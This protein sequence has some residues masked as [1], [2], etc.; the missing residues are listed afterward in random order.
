MHGT[1]EGSA[2]LVTL[3]VAL[4]AAWVGAVLSVRLRISAIFGYIVAGIAIGPH[5]PGFQGDVEVVDAL[6]EI[7]VI[8]LMFSVGVDL[9]LRRLLDVGW[10][11]FLAGGVQVASVLAIAFSAGLL[12]G[13]PLAEAFCFGSAIAISSSVGLGKLLAE[14]GETGSLHGQIA[15]AF[16][17]VQDLATIVLVILLRSLAGGDG[18][19]TE[20]LL[21]AVGKALLFLII[22]VPVGSR[23]FPW[24]FERVAL[25]RNRELFTL[26]V[27]AVALA[28]AS[29]ASLF[30][31]SLALGAFIAGIV[32]SES[33]LSH[34]I[35]ATA[36]SLRD[37]FAG[38]FFVS[39][40][41]LLDP[42][43]VVADWR[44]LFAVVALIMLIKPALVAAIVR[45]LG[46]PWRTGVL[47]GGA[48]AHSAEFSFLLATT[49][50]GLGILS[51]NVFA[52]ILTASIVSVVA[53]PGTYRLAGVVGDWLRRRAK[54]VDIAPLAEVSPRPPAVIL[55][56]GRVGQV[57]AGA[58]ARR[59]LSFVAVDEDPDVVR[60]LWEQG[61]PAVLG[62]A[63]NP[64]LLDQLGLDHARLLI[65]ALP[66][67]LAT[68]IIVEHVR[69][70][71]PRL[72]IIARC[73][74]IQEQET[75]L[76]LGVQEAVVGELELAIEMTRFALRRF[77]VSAAEIQG[78]L[79][80]LRS[81]AEPADV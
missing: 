60:R 28:V 63:D 54:P 6:A 3:A 20:D 74:S 16:S 64:F 75:L 65:I 68:R 18:A 2:L 29:S 66:D 32:V 56:Y 51:S 11:A 57:I 55:G 59:G 22:L 10:A 23:L 26:T 17:T 44:L 73:H 12:F 9:S 71:Y 48:L 67:A 7:G 45:G 21:L 43:A 24:L 13:W 79:R 31:L 35:L 72:P 70:T 36:G 38:I 42:V 39:I 61:R 40:G 1:G 37:I 30:G 62:E 58:L 19:T 49:G 77:G 80:R 76:A 52:L 81:P 47:V 69:S 34:R 41:M 78:I 46:H 27:A 53:A 4:G 50:L 25:L 5:T 33:E 14:R 8:L 15:L